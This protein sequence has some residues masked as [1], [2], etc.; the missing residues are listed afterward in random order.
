M[1]INKERMMS[2]LKAAE[3]TINKSPVPIME[4]ARLFTENGKLHLWAASNVCALEFFIQETDYR[5]DI[6]FDPRT[7]AEGLKAVRGDVFN[8]DHDMMLNLHTEGGIMQLAIENGA[9]YP[10]LQMFTDEGDLIYQGDSA[11]ITGAIE[12]AARFRHDQEYYIITSGVCIA[13]TDKLKVYGTDT[14]SL[15]SLEV[16]GEVIKE[17]TGVIPGAAGAIIAGMP[18]S[19]DTRLEIGEFVTIANQDWRL[20]MNK[21]DGKYPVD[22]IEKVLAE[23]LPMEIEVNPKEL[24]AAID[25]VGN[26]TKT[27]TVRIETATDS[28]TV[29]ASSYEAHTHAEQKVFAT[30][31]PGSLEA[32]FKSL[33]WALKTGGEYFDRIKIQRSEK[34]LRAE[35]GPGILF[36]TSLIFFH[37]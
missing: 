14:R 18:A 29:K 15:I 4:M 30:A 23:D 20:T 32:N 16:Q 34:F 37:K 26:F 1:L 9:E 25:M 6:C 33:S 19:G 35:I 5:I 11:E 22:L 21:G 24:K 10:K 36:A 12:V 17:A 28:L 2:A 31:T 13:A 27:Y 8:I 3:K 7:L